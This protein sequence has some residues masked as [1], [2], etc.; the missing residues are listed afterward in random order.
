MNFKVRELIKLRGAKL[1]LGLRKRREGLHKSNPAK[2]YLKPKEDTRSA[3]G[4]RLDM[5]VGL[6]VSG[7]VAFFLLVNI[8]G[9]PANAAVF[10]LLL[11]V[12]EALLL[13]KALH[14]KERRRRLQKQLYLA[15][16]KFSEDIVNM[17]PKSQFP[18]Y[19]CDI[20]TRLPGFQLRAKAKKEDPA[21]DNQGF[22]LE[23]TY[24]GV[25]LGV[26]C[27]HQVGG[28]VT[29]ADVRAFAG[30]LHLAGYNNGL[31]VTTGDFA[32]GVRRVV[33]EAARKGIKIK[34]V[35]RYGLAE[36]ARQAGC[37]V[38]QSTEAGPEVVPRTVPKKPSMVL[39]ALQD[40]VFSSRKKAKGYF[41]YGLLLLAGYFL[42]KGTSAL[43]LVY[44]FFAVLNLLLG[45]GS[46][47]YG[48]SVE[49]LDP[50]EGFNPEK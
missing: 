44:L 49:E 35:T 42:L 19:V 1:F 16:E 47:Y 10:S 25:P 23:G 13:K 15:G 22:D 18:L 7:L 24:K 26:W 3:L 32:P 39:A 5:L 21:G 27:L 11:L 46:L 40:S 6:L 14:L 50:L 9:Q 29:P 8:T 41:I 20:L 12:L 17:E 38:F 48:R 2:F 30:A 43:S 31:L 28:E 4:R 37:S 34:A 36:L 45:A 33:G